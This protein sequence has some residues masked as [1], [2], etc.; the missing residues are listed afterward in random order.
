MGAQT[1]TPAE[2]TIRAKEEK[3]SRFITGWIETGFTGNFDT[4]EDNQNFGRLL[5]DRSNELVMNQ[6]VINFEREFEKA[7]EFDWGL[8]LQLLFGTDAR[9]LR[10]LGM[11]YHQAETG[12]YQGDVPEVF[13]RLHLPVI[14]EGGVDVVI[15]KFVTLAGVETVDPRPNLFYS[16]TYIFNFGLPTNH[17]GVL[18][19]L[20]ADKTLDLNAGITRGVNT[21]VEDNND[22]PGFHGGFNWKLN[23]DKVGIL[24]ATHIGPESSDNDSDLRFISDIAF[25]WKIHDQLTSITEVN[26]VRDDGADADA[27]GAAQYLTYKF[28]ETISASIRGEVWR[29]D[30]A[31]YV[32]QY[33]DPLDPFR[34]SNGRATIDPRTI[35]GGRTTYCALTIGLDINIPVPK[36]L[37]G[38]RIR[39]ELRVDRSMNENEVFNDSR[40]DRMFTAALDALLTF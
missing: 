13:L 12:E 30:K 36:P 1:L 8:R 25:T 14:T 23:D 4:P 20:H 5:D 7:D 6:A 38:L 29:D 2:E 33:A 9:Y 18:F 32:A 34:S 37:A 22:A 11:R 27:Y 31:F 16:H 15:G 39:P 19:T 10:S 35:A 26:Y 24:A 21:S 28:N 40:D 3:K 17:T